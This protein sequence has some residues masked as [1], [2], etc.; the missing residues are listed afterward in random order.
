VINGCDSKDIR[1]IAANGNILQVSETLTDPDAD[2]A[3]LKLSMDPKIP[4]LFLTGQP[5]LAIG[6]QVAIWGFPVGYSGGAP[7]LTVGYVAGVDRVQVAERK[8]QNRLIVNAA[9]NAGNSGGPIINVEDGTV[10]GIVASKLAPIPSEIE[11][12]LQALHD[13]KYGVMYNGRKADGTEVQFSEAQIVSGVLN[14]L[15]SQTQ[16]VIGQ[17]VTA[18]DIHHF[19]K[20]KKLEK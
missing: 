17:A 9:F 14:Y 8:Y 19:L 1:I 2:L 20:E 6:A 7:L 4:P 16:V 13:N 11:G 10:I 5:D 3:A 18:D 12:A 15:R